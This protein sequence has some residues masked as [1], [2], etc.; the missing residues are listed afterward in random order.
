MNHLLRICAAQALVWAGLLF[1]A[2]EWLADGPIDPL[3]RTLGHGWA[4]AQ[5]VLA[6]LF[7]WGA[8]A[9]VSHIPVVVAA[10]GLTA[11]RVLVD[12]VGLLGPLPPQPGVYFVA[13]LL[14]G[15][16]LLVG[17]LEALPRT[18]P[19]RASDEAD[20]PPAS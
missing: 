14:V 9:P 19:G 13:D 10:I 12:L 11:T 2:P 3:G 20:A 18:L 6:A 8:R 4:S 1:V 7:L 17:L 15:F 5:I 16:A